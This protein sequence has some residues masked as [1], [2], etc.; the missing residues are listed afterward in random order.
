M[1]DQVLTRR[2]YWRR[3]VI[4]IITIII[5]Y[6]FIKISFHEFMTLEYADFA[7]FFILPVGNFTSEF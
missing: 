5:I 6:E 7:P 4:V 1:G 2:Q 3:S